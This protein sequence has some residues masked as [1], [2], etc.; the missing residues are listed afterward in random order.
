MKKTKKSKVCLTCGY[1]YNDEWYEEH[2]P[3]N[4]S[5]KIDVKL[6]K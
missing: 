4:K 2:P 3:L 1:E 5:N 6:V